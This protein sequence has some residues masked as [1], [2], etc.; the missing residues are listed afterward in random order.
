MTNVKVTVNG[1]KILVPAGVT[2]M[3]ACE[4]A[5]EEIPRFCYH[6]RLSIAG[7]CR[8]CLVEIEK[9][10]KPVASCAMPVIEDMVIKTKTEKVKKA[11]KGVME[12]LLINHPLD[13]PICD[14]GGECD[15]QDQ[16]IYY[17]K[18][19][20]RFDESKRAVEEKNFGPLIKT[21]MT[22]CIHCTRCV[23]FMDE[24]AGSHDL[25]AINRGEDV[26]ITNSLKEGLTS[27][28]SGN[29]IDLCPVGALTSKPYAFK[30]R[31]WELKHY[32]SIDI[33]DPVCSN[34]RID[35]FGGEIKRVLPRLNEEINQE[36]ISD[37]S[38]FSY[39][40]LYN[41]RLDKPYL[42][43]KSKLS[44]CDW[45]SAIKIFS[46]KIKEVNAEDIFAFSGPLVDVETLYV[47]KNL[48]SKLGI[49]NIDC[50]SNASEA[51]FSN[52][53]EWLFNEGIMGIDKIDKLFILGA[54]IK[55]EAP[56][57]NSR[58]RQRWLSGELKIIGLCVPEDLNYDLQN[59]GND[60]S[61]LNNK[62]F[63]KKFY[64]FFN[65][66]EYP[67]MILGDK[68]LC[69]KQGNKIHNLSKLLA[70][71]SKIIRNN[72]NGFSYLSPCASRVGALE[73]GFYPKK[74]KNIINSLINNKLENKK[75]VILIENDDFD[76]NKLNLDNCFIIYIGHHGDKVAN[77]ADLI[78]PC[79]AFTEK[80]ALYLNLEGRPQFTT[81]VTDNLGKAVDSWKIF[82]ALAD[83]VKVKLNYNDHEQLL[84][85]LFKKYPHFSLINNLTPAKWES[86][87][88]QEIKL[89]KENINTT[90]LNFYQTC[91][92]SRSSSNMAS[93]VKEFVQNK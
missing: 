48:F 90:M 49:E 16:S 93:C 10:P 67:M 13:C 74:R 5:G 87:T 60:I 28:M 53:S 52:R 14:Q 73:V 26:E 36:W 65:K 22:R 34:I 70:Q 30:A 80:T 47:A 7:N 24:V 66:S 39:D 41:Q 42:K 58:I 50:R 82:R 6:E 92:I 45:S 9:S 37:K 59:F 76:I 31:S 69:S 68:I 85:E 72:W 40:G 32:D 51:D 71:K 38:R 23:R 78:L 43:K 44:E 56:T 19:T 18:S 35:E 63:L 91:S 75:L 84:Q 54:D 55:R 79:T 46:E 64:S 77:K 83:E 15:L 21:V 89:E 86:L 29:I 17:G 11:R 4:I 57:L 62:D 8:M 27:E 88:T 3:Q 1:K 2:V 61:L 20:S 33:M 12:F 25:G 81:K